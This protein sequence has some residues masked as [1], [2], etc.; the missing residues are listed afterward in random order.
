MIISNT[1]ATVFVMGNKAYLN[2]GSICSLDMISPTIYG[3]KK[4]A[5]K[6]RPVVCFHSSTEEAMWLPVITAI[7]L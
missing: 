2:S 1:N 5:L 6:E 7:P 3:L 4:P